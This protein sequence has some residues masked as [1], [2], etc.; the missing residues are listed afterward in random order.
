MSDPLSTYLHDHLAGA[1]AAIR[2]R[3]VRG[4]RAV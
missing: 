1:K 2:I 4:E 3:R